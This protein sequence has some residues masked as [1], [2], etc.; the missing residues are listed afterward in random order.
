MDP[1]LSKA[2]SVF[3]LI[4]LGM[5]ALQPFCLYLLSSFLQMGD[6]KTVF[7][8]LFVCTFLICTLKTLTGKKYIAKTFFLRLAE[9]EK[10]IINKYKMEQIQI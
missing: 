5:V 4:R 3:R 8:Q 6:I 7:I 1:V 2:L 9:V 10:L